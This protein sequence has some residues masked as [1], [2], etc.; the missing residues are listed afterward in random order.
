MSDRH[1]WI[2]LNYSTNKLKDLANELRDDISGVLLP[3]G[4]LNE[5]DDLNKRIIGALAIAA[6]HIERLEYHHEPL[7]SQIVVNSDG[8]IHGLDLMGRVWLLDKHSTYW[9]IIEK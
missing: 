3:G 5:K 1:M 7:F 2:E 4:V 8:V 9:S 6:D